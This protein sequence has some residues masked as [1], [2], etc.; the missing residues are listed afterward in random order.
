LPTNVCATP[1]ANLAAMAF[2]IG[3]N[4]DLANRAVGTTATAYSDQLELADH[5]VDHDI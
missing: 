1:A 5:V 3:K 4:L 2:A